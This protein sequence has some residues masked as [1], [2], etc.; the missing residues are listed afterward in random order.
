MPADIWIETIPFQ[1]TRQYVAAV[2]EYRAVYSRR[3][4]NEA[5]TM[6]RHLPDVMPA[7]RELAP[8]SPAII[9]AACDT[10]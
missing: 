9:A 2:L 6:T 3:L 1:E 7:A 4:G 10:W 8:E 5:R